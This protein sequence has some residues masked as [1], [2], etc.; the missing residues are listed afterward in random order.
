[1]EFI[2]LHLIGDYI[3]QTQWMASQKSSCSLAALVH[4]IVYSFPFL[5][6]GSIQAV[7]L[8]LVTH[9]FVDRFRLARYVVFAKNWVTEPSLR[10]GNVGPTGFPKDVP[11]WLSTMLLIVVDNT[12]HLMCN[13]AALTWF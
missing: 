6:I 5:L 2:L 10:W 11:V 7:S 12:I 4:A 8:I 3:T 1:M 13:Y 9:F